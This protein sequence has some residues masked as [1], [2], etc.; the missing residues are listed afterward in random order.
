MET[1]N[2]TNTNPSET[3]V[4]EW[5]KQYGKLRKITVT[6]DEENEN[7]EALPCLHFY[8]KRNI[9]N[10][11]A[12]LTLANKKLQENKDAFAYSKII[13]NAFAINGQAIFSDHEDVLIAMMPY[14]DGLITTATAQLGK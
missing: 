4:A 13:L 12:T 14:V 6:L 1:N 9:P 5:T 11:I 2:K 10:K 7:G 8:F 3:E